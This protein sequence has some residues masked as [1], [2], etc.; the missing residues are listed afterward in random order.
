MD[1]CFPRIDP[2]RTA[3]WDKYPLGEHIYT[4]QAHE[5]ACDCSGDSVINNPPQQDSYDKS[6]HSP[7]I[8]TEPELLGFY[9]Y[10][11]NVRQRHERSCFL[12][13]STS[14]IN[15]PPIRQHQIL[16]AGLPAVYQAAFRLQHR[17]HIFFIH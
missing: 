12:I 16:G 9:L 1:F 15:Q 11:S 14:H 10:R 3:R 4:H 17:I 8:G 5:N 2:H 7:E 6:E 13:R